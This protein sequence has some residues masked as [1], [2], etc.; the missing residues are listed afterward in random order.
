MTIAAL[1]AVKKRAAADHAAAMRMMIGA[2]PAAAA[3]VV[4]SAIQ[5]DTP[6]PPAAVGKTVA[7]PEGGAEGCSPSAPRIG[8]KNDRKR[9]D[10]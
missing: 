4:G 10:P 7:R 1:H 6:K 8:T 9:N 5:K 3:G 2:R